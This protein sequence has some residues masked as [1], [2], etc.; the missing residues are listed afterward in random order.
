MLLRCIQAKDLLTASLNSSCPASPRSS[1]T[2]SPSTHD[3]KPTSECKSLISPFTSA[4][5]SIYTL[6]CGID[7][8]EA[9]YF[10]FRDLMGVYVYTFKDCINACAIY[11]NKGATGNHGNST[12]YAVSFNFVLPEDEGNCWLKGHQNIPFQSNETVDSAIL[13][14]S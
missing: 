9:L 14:L 5:G 8:K 12:C 11:N 6:E 3:I 4:T 2:T 13:E 10:D 1:N 7:L